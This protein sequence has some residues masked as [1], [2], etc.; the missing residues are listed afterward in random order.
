MTKDPSQGNPVI[1]QRW[2]P[3]DEVS[4]WR[5]LCKL[6]D[7]A[8]GAINHWRR[9]QIAVMP[10]WTQLIVGKGLDRRRYLEKAV[11][12]HWSTLFDCLLIADCEAQGCSTL[13]RRT[14]HRTL[15]EIVGLN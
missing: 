12:C 14:G 1:R 3:V 7:L 4:E 9:S 10:S 8:V 2:N 6:L 13:C 15:D 5:C 11:G